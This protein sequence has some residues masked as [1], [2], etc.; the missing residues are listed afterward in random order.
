MVGQ[1]DPDDT[2]VVKVVPQRVVE[3][4]LSGRVPDDDE[5]AFSSLT[6]SLC[7]REISFV[8]DDEV[9]A[10]FSEGTEIAI[11]G[12]VG[13]TVVDRNGCCFC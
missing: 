12:Q 4:A 10:A 1:S 2:A 13:R 3:E 6:F 11:T 8:R 7:R 5:M 9:V